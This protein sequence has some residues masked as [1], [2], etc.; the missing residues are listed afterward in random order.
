MDKDICVLKKCQSLTIEGTCG[1]GRLKKIRDE[2]MKHDLQ[3]LGFTEAMTC[4]RDLWQH[5]ML[6]KACQAKV[7]QSCG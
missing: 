7:N 2:V 3:M 1:R 4:D 6:E 5:T